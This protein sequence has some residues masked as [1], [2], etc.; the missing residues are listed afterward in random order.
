M[1]WVKDN[2]LGGA[3]R[4]AARTQA[5]AADRAAQQQ[6]EAEARARGDLQP[7]RDLGAGVTNTLLD[8]VLQGPETDLERTRGFEDIQRS[9][10]AGGKL[11][12]GGTLE[13]LTGFN[14]ML[15]ARNRRDRFSE[16]FN[17][18]TLGSNAAA[19]QAT[20]TLRTGENI[21]SLTVGKGDALAAGQVAGANAIRGTISDLARIGA[22]L[23][24]GG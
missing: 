14:N 1:S 12:S 18:A 20:N 9:A 8:F 10:A 4:D 22:S 23:A 6:R 16:L 3:E 7:F 5:D 15:N 17:L 2:F 13:E 21:S 19:G 24:G 11:T